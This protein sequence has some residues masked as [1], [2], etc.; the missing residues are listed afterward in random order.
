MDQ[1]TVYIDMN[2]SITI[3]FAGAQHVDVVQGMSENSFI[4]S[5][6]LCASTTGQKLPPMIIFPGVG[7]GTVEEEL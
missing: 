3:D 2:P 6:F 4:A 1:T 5:V 7:G